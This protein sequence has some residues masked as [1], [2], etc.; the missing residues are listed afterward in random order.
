[1][2]ADL[3]SLEGKR[4]L[5]GC[6]RGIGRAMAV[7]LAKAGADIVG[8]S[9]SLNPARSDVGAEIEALEKDSKDFR[10]ISTIGQHCTHLSSVLMSKRLIL[11]YWLTM[12]ARY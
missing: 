3:F 12:R 11:I 1:M 4:A 5:N 8:V 2:I 7:A 10:L 9:A 6:K